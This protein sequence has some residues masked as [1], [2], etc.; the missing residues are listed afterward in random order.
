[1]TSCNGVTI[2]AARLPRYDVPPDGWPSPL[3]MTETAAFYHHR[4]HVITVRDTA[5]PHDDSLVGFHIPIHAG[6]DQNSTDSPG[7]SITARLP[8][9][10]FANSL[11]SA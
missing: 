8:V 4:P 11:G 3:A 7:L 10:F 9:T 2:E 6:P 5:E 1:M